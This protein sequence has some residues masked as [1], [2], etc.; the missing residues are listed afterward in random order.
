MKHLLIFI[1][2]ILILGCQKSNEFDYD[3]FNKVNLKSSPDNFRGHSGMV[4]P[5]VI[6]LPDGFQP[7]GIVIGPNHTFF[8]GSLNSGRIYRGDLQ[9]GAG[10]II[11]EPSLPAQ[12]LGLAVDKRN[13]YL[14]VAGGFTGTGSVYNYVTGELEQEFTFAQPGTALINDVTVT[15]EAVY[16]TNSFSPVLYK[17]PFCKKGEFGEPITLPLNGFSMEQS[18]PESQR[19]GAFSNGIDATPSGKKL[20]IAN[21][22]RGELYLVNP[23]TG[24]SSLIDL[25]GVILPFAD[26]ILLEGKTLYVVQNFMNQVS[27][28]T[29]SDDFLSGTLEKTINDPKF[30]VPTTIGG[31]GNHLYVLNSHFNTAPPTGIFP[32]VKFEVV[33][34][35]K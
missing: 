31:F 24:A 25:G 5:D 12:A 27:V 10:D 22:D 33:K 11:I 9:T 4:F 20:I 16:F 29:L 8:V 30:V 28:I 1:F 18:L 32:N 26:G 6:P 2:L 3:E 13:N 23:G 17:I 21:T 14:F 7:E 19:L 15:R 35:E 34:V